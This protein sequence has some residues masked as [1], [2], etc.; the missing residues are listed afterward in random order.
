MSAVCRRWNAL[1]DDKAFVK[2]VTCEQSI[3]DV[4]ASADPG[5][6]LVVE[7]GFYTV[8]IP[9]SYAI[10]GLVV[11]RL[12]SAVSDVGAVTVGNLR[13]NTFK[14]QHEQPKQQHC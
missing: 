10:L 1:A 14:I 7:A 9:L 6:T 13:R 4:V 2:R 3:N 5:D 11:C 12:T 8:A